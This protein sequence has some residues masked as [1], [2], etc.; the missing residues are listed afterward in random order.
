MCVVHKSQAKDHVHEKGVLG[1]LSSCIRYSIEIVATARSY[2]K[3]K[4]VYAIP[5]RWRCLFRPNSHD[6]PLT[7]PLHRVKIAF[8][9]CPEVRLVPVP[10]VASRRFGSHVQGPGIEGVVGHCNHALVDREWR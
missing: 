9:K 3:C 10:E 5:V 1:K 8:R 4:L 7:E 2:L 6:S